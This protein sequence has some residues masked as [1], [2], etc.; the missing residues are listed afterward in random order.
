MARSKHLGI[1]LGTLLLCSVIST[2]SGWAASVNLVIDTDPGVDDA[3]ALVWLLYQNTYS[4]NLLGIGTVFGNTS[5]SNG[6][7][8][9]LTILDAAGR[10]GIPVAIGA[11]EPLSQPFEAGPWLG[12]RSPALLHGSDG[13]WGIGQSHPRRRFER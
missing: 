9:V 7:N 12:L 2:A 5:P 8:N 3:A 11:P 13:L 4:V 1:A 10:H 6:A